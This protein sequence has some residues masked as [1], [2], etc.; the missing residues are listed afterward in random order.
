MQ[1]T[2]VVLA[3][4]ASA[5]AA[6]IPRSPLGSWKVSLEQLNS[7]GA[8]YTDAVYTSDAYPE[9]LATHCVLNTSETPVF[10]RCDQLGVTADWDGKSKSPRKRP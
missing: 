1:F 8:L 5:S 3:L 6:V 7:N 4:A 10:N 2:T 9:G